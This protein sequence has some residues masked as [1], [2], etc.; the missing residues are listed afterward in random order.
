M[1]FHN[2]MAI[3]R[4]G[5]QGRAGVAS[6]V[7]ASLAM[8][9]GPASA[10]DV[11]AEAKLYDATHNQVGK[12]RLT[13]LGDGNVAVHISV[14]DLTPGFHGF[15]VHAIGKCT[16]EEGVAPFTSAGGH[17]DIGGHTH[18][19]HSGDFPVLL[20]HADGTANVKLNTDRFTL[21]A[22][23]DGDGSA[24]ILH[25]NR[26]NY[27]NIPDRYTAAGTTAP[28]PDTTTLATGDSG[29]RVACGALERIVKRD[30]GRSDDDDNDR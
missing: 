26:D 30:K 7:L 25:A 3:F 10:Y 2:A 6:I 20:V 24:I 14:H 4:P 12:A 13:Q 27:A 11:S 5:M 1:K 17:F 16:I 21:D 9:A 29:G 15:H 22:L 19:N 23:F 8:F 28:G 18:G